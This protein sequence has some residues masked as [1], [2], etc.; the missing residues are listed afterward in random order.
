M[1]VFKKGDKQLLKGYLPVSL[2]P[3]TGKIFERFIYYQIFEFFIR[4]G[5]FSQNQ[6]RFKPG[7]SWINQLLAIIP[8]IYKS[9]DALS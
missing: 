6:S 2:L 9:F 8:V 3:I 4:N 5:L 7:G 1:P